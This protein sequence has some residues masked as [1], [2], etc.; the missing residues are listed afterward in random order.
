V[1]VLPSPF[2]AHL[3]V[4]Q[5]Y[6]LGLSPC[7]QKIVARQVSTWR[8]GSQ[9]V[10]L[11]SLCVEVKDFPATATVADETAKFASGQSFGW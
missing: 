9:L 3:A 5:S 10:T 7:S 8:V 6:G 4:D 11:E 2:A 1:T